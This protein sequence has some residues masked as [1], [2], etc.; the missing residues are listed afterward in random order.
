MQ[1]CSAAQAPFLCCGRQPWPCS[2][3]RLAPALEATGH[4]ICD[5]HTSTP[6]S[7]CTCL[8]LSLPSAHLQVLGAQN[9]QGIVQ[10]FRGLLHR[11]APPAEGGQHLPRQA[12][13]GLKAVLRRHLLQQ[14][15]AHTLVLICSL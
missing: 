6:F 1:R 4:F 3:P 14:E 11:Q 13:P 15:P 10:H 9:G 5:V 8:S 12:G 7:M 2:I